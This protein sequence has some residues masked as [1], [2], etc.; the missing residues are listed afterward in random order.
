MATSSKPGSG[1]T[2]PNT[3]GSASGS[4]PV[5]P[6]NLSTPTSSIEVKGGADDSSRLKLVLGILRKWVLLEQLCAARSDEL[7]N[8][9]LTAKGLLECQISRLFASLYLL[10]SLNLFRILVRPSTRCCITLTFERVLALHWQTRDIREVCWSC[11]WRMVA[12]NS[13]IGSSD[14]ELGRMLEVVRFWC[15]KDLKFVKGK[16]IKPYN[17]TLGEFFR[18]C[19]WKVPRYEHWLLKCNWDIQQESQ[20]FSTPSKAPPQPPP[21]PCNAAGNAE[22]IRISYLTEQTSHHPP[23]SA[24]YVECP[25]KGI[26]ARGYDQISAQFKG[27]FMKVVKVGGIQLFALDRSDCSLWCGLCW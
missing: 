2:T 13:S 10:S 9:I 25:A 3:L 11:H 16:P 26:V 5:T 8:E 7:Q 1:A 22:P 27:T 23:V 14:D 4:R 18:V 19:L 6:S 12:Y 17:S 24:Y 21:D 15:T 20:P